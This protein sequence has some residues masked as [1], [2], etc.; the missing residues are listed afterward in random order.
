MEKNT[1]IISTDE[2]YNLREFKDRINCG[3]SCKIDVLY[4]GS[5]VD[6]YHYY[7]SKD[8]IVLELGQKLEKTEKLLELAKKEMQSVEKDFITNVRKL[9][10]WDLIKLK[11][12]KHEN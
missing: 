5:N 1:V 9:S 12:Y 8:D 4:T 6:R 7:V 11:L 10:W 3:Y 2:Y